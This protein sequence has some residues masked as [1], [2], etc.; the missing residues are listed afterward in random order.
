MLG[1]ATNATPKHPT[2]SGSAPRVMIAPMTRGWWD[3]GAGWKNGDKFVALFRKVN[4]EMGT[5]NGF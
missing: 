2:R 3:Y 4:A 1:I 5:M